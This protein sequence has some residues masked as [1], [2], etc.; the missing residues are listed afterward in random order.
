MTRP[1]SPRLHGLLDY[2]FLGVLLSAPTLLGLAR[3]VRA[4]FALFGLAQSGLNA[5]TDQP[6]AVRRAVPF[7]LHG[8]IEKYSTPLYVVGPGLVGAWRDRRALA[9]QILAG[10]TL[11]TVYNLTDWDA[12]NTDR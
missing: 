5:V 9:F 4:V 1:I 12:R 2:G 7:K 8:Q 10:A 6:Y 11:V 3:P